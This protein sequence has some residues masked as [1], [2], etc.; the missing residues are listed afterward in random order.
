MVMLVVYNRFRLKFKIIFLCFDTFF[1]WFQFLHERIFF[2]HS[3]GCAW[4]TMT[5]NE[6]FNQNFVTPTYQRNIYHLSYIAQFWKE[7]RS[8]STV[9]HKKKTAIC[10]FF[11]IN[12]YRKVNSALQFICQMIINDII[13]MWLLIR[14]IFKSNLKCI[15]FCYTKRSFIIYSLQNL[16]TC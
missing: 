3:K 16:L 12:I 4:C 10:S 11:C 8:L 1:F 7:F 15:W 9:F 6:N 14:F 5:T 2:I 13:T